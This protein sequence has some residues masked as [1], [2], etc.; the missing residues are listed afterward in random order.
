MQQQQ[1]A[2]TPGAPGEKRKMNL[3]VNENRR[4][5]TKKEDKKRNTAV[6]VSNLPLDASIDELHDV[7]KKCG[8]IMED[9]QTGE[10]SFVV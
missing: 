2:Y 1:A 8:V 9:V 5:K 10:T 4:K 3:S 6:F 7:F